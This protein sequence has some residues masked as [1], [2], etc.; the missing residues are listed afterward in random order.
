MTL[1]EFL[2]VLALSGFGLWQLWTAWSRGEVRSRY[3]GMVRRA[4]QPIAFWTIVAASAIF[5]LACAVAA[6]LIAWRTLVPPPLA[7]RE[8]ALYPTRAAAQNVSGLVVLRCT[9]TE[10]YGVKDCS[11]VSESP[12]GQGFAAS[13]LQISALQ[14]LPEKDRARA[15][16]GSEIN[17]P[18]RFKIPTPK[19]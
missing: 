14:V 8:S 11:V 4:D 13:A 15:V 18:I 2:G 19:R 1:L 9:V 5:P 6:V 3:G 7:Q 12:P 17:L 16:P 10:T